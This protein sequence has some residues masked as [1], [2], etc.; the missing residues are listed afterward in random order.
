MLD[1][2]FVKLGLEII[3]KPFVSNNDQ[4]KSKKK[5]I[6]LQYTF[7]FSPYLCKIL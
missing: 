4:F 7:I 5:N 6:Q 1:K 3:Q 2:S